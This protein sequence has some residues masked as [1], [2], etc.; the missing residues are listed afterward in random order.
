MVR[1]L[2]GTLG[3]RAALVAG[4]VGSSGVSNEIAGISRDAVHLLIGTPGKLN[5]VMTT[6]ISGS[7]VRLLIVSRTWQTDQGSY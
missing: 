5:E 1:G 3:V 2:G 7:E 6:G 4:A